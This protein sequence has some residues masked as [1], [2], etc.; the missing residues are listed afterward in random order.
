[1][2]RDLNELTSYMQPLCEQFLALAASSGIPC[3]I[4]DTGR[5][6]AQQQADLSAHRSWTSHSKHLPQPPE[7]KSEAFDAVP[8]A[9]LDGGRKDYDPESPL[10]AQ[11]GAIGKKLGLKWGGDFKVFHNGKW[12]PRP[13]PGHF[14]YVHTPAPADLSLQG[15]V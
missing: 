15:D 5:T 3:V 6:E 9:I 14:Q 1:M 7:M 8:Q 4:E 12:I 2:G 10:W 11:I 13:D